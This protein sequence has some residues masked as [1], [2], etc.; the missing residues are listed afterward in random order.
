MEE[1]TN[2][3]KIMVFQNLSQVLLIE[4]P[5]EQAYVVILELENRLLESACFPMTVNQFSKLLRTAQ[6]IFTM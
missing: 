1:C 3:Q 6:K 2:Q 4:D 5:K